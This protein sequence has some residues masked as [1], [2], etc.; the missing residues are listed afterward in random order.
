VH[1]NGSFNN[2]TLG[3]VNI[4]QATPMWNS[5]YPWGGILNLKP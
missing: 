4:W 3:P 5:P 1:H 2:D